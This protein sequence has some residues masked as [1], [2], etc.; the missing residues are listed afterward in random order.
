M[1]MCLFYLKDS[2]AELVGYA[3]VVYRSDPNKGKSQ[4]GYVLTYSDTV[5]S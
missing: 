2:K 1:N 3:N 5:I 4:T